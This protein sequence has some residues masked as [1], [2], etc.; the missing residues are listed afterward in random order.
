MQF[1]LVHGGW[2]GGWSWNR[3]ASVLRARG[4]QVFAPT[5]RGSDIAAVGKELVDAIKHADLREVA[6]IGHSGDGA[7]L[8]Y[9]AERLSEITRRVVFVDAWEIQDGQTIHA[10]G[11]TPGVMPETV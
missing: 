4:H 11:P 5:L 10:A 7:V 6:L 3:V 9:A 8:R 2:L 1:V